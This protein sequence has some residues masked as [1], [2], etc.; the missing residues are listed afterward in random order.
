MRSSVFRSTELRSLSV[1]C[2]TFSIP[3]RFCLNWVLKGS[4]NSSLLLLILVP[5]LLNNESATVSAWFQLTYSNLDGINVKLLN[6]PTP[7]YSP[8]VPSRL[9]G[10]SR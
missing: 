10:I 5:T 8:E 6:H 4:F 7:R 2:F 3:Q 9:L 1:L